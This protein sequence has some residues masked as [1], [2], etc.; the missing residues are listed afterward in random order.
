MA[1]LGKNNKY[2]GS[3]FGTRF[4]MKAEKYFKNISLALIYNFSEQTLTVG[5]VLLL[6][7]LG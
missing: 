1:E 2:D 7:A 5:T 6:Y 3:V 4:S